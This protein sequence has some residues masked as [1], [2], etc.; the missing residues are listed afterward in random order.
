MPR[1][2]DEMHAPVRN[3]APLRPLPAAAQ[4]QANGALDYT[5]ENGRGRGV[6]RHE[7]MRQARVALPLTQQRQL[8]LEQRT[9]SRNDAQLRGDLIVVREIASGAEPVKQRHLEV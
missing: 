3:H 4:R 5:L 9:R 1:V 7:W 6:I 2:M 8:G